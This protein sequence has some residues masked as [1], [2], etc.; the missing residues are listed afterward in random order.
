MATL[1]SI[2]FYTLSDERARNASSESQ[3][4]RVEI[5]LTDKCNFKCPYCRGSDCGTASLMSVKEI[6]DLCATR[7]LKNIRFSGGEPTLYPYLRE[8]VS[9]ARERGVTRIALSTNGSAPLAFY[10]ELISLGVNDLSISLDACCASFGK[11]MLGGIDGMWERV[12]E[13]IKELSKLTYVTLGCVFTEETVDTLPDVVKFGHELGVADIR[14]ISSAQYNS[15]LKHVELIDKNLLEFHPILKY[16]VM[17]ILRGRG[18]RGLN[19]VDNHKCPLVLDD[20]AISGNKHFP[21]II[22]MREK[23]KEIGNMNGNVFGERENW[24]NSHDTYEDPICKI[25]C[26]DV[27]VDYINKW[28][29][30]HGQD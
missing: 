24:Y 20:I 4:Q 26:L 30:F 19:E 28:R 23:G 14:I 8:V 11:E 9:Y 12:V 2:G 13:N 7:N 6:I 27:C 21:C 17:N 22:Y 1:E 10:K 16:R 5:L 3:L 15:T 25:N 29:E 18:V